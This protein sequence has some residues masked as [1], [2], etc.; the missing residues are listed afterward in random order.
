[1]RHVN[2]IDPDMEA[3]R[4]AFSFGIDNDLAKRIR[5]Q[6]KEKWESGFPCLSPREAGKKR[7]GEPLIKME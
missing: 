2:L 7:L 6:G 5:N 3:F 1:M 4:Q